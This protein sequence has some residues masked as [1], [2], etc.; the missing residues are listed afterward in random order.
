VR[1][2]AALVQAAAADVVAVAAGRVQRQA[3][4]AA[5]PPVVQAARALA[6]DVDVV[7][8]VAAAAD[9]GLAAE[10]APTVKP[11]NVVIA[12]AKYAKTVRN[13]TSA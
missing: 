12:A 8:A 10:I 5:Q 13:L 4:L 1:V 11:V 2:A 3:V 7:A 6:A 9:H